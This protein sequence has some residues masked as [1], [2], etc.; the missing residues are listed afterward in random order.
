MKINTDIISNKQQMLLQNHQ[1]N[2]MIEKNKKKMNNLNINSD[3]T[4]PD[5]EKLKKVVKDFSSIFIKKMFKSMRDTLP[6]EKLIDGGFAEDVFTDMLDKE[7]S[8]IGAKQSG[9]DNLNQK[10]YQ[11]L[12]RKQ[13]IANNHNQ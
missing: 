6:E 13:M 4:G 1:Y 2:N 12:L 8:K 3:K 10:L 5:K 11:Q 9:F 7:I